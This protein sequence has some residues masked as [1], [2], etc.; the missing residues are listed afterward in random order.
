ML[1]RGKCRGRGSNPQ[2]GEATRVQ[3][4]RVCQ[5]R[6]R[7]S[8]C[9]PGSLSVRPYRS[10]GLLTQLGH[11]LVFYDSNRDSAE[12]KERARKAALLPAIYRDL[13]G[14]YNGQLPADEVIRG[15]LVLELNFSEPAA[16]DVLREFRATLE[17]ARVEG[18]EAGDTLSGDDEEDDPAEPEVDP[19]PM[20]TPTLETPESDPPV[21]LDKM[22]KKVPARTVQVT[23][24][25]DEWALLQA[26]FPLS[27][28]EWDKM[29]AV[30]QGMKPGLVR[31]TSSRAPAGD[32]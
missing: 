31:E 12:W 21:K 22:P 23:Y 32:E 5:F 19:N 6:H 1:L 13:W 17:F 24:S 27:E 11:E 4:G 26:P 25:P 8:G 7:G 9:A 30:L 20:S 18:S 3:F 10:R 15:Y 29:L 2:G 28:A 14:K 16:K